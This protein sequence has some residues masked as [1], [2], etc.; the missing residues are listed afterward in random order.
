MTWVIEEC[1]GQIWEEEKCTHSN[2]IKY[3]LNH[4][5]ILTYIW[6]KVDLFEG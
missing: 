2:E 3:D 1:K 6:K 4:Q 5:N